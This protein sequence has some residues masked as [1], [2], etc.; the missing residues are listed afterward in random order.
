MKAVVGEPERVEELG[1]ALQPR[2][3]GGWG[4]GL[5]AGGGEEGGGERRPSLLTNT[6]PD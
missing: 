3:G 4:P 2:R 1:Q 5:R 6:S